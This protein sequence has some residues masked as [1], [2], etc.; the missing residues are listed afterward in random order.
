[1]NKEKPLKKKEAAIDAIKKTYIAPRLTSYGD[2]RR[3]TLGKGSSAKDNPV[4]G[5]KTKATGAA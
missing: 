4:T 3:L 2:F 5:L 1:M